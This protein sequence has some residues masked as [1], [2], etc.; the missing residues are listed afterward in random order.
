MELAVDPAPRAPAPPAVDPE[1]G[2]PKPAA[3]DGAAAEAEFL[4]EQRKY[5]LLQA[6]LAATVT[7]A[8][9]LSPPGGFWP[10]NVKGLLAGDPVLRVTYPRRYQ[11]F[12]YCNATAFVASLVTVNLLLVRSLSHRRRWLRALQAAMVLDQFGLMAAYAAGS[13]RDTA[14]SAYVFVLVALVAAYVTAHVLFFRLRPPPL[15]AAGH[16]DADADADADAAAGAAAGVDNA[17]AATPG[18]GRKDSVDRA[19]KHLLIFATLAATVTYSAGLST[20]GGFWPGSSED[21]EH[22]AGDPLLRLHHPDRFMVFFY[23]NTTAFVSSLVVIMLL[24]SSTLSRHGLRSSALWV[25]AGAAMAGL[26]GAFA[27]GS[28]RSV[29]TSIFVVSL[30]AAVLFYIGIQILVFL[31]EPV[32]ILI[33]DFQEALESYLQFRRLGEQIHQHQQ[34]Q[35]RV[36]FEHGGDGDTAAYQ[37]LRKS[38]MYL[39]LLGIL[40]ASVTYQAGLNPP[41]GFWQGDAA[42]GIHHYLAGDPILHITY[43]RRYLVFFYCNATAFV[44]SLVILI[45]LLSNI[46]STHGIK[47]CALQVAMILDLFGLVGAYAAGSCRQASK[48]VYVAVIVVPV[49]LYVGIH[50][51]VF[52]VKSFPACAAWREDTRAAMERRAPEWLKEVFERHPEGDEAM[53]RKLEKR[54]KLLLLLAILAAS[55]TYQAGM[56]PPGGFWQENESGHVV[57]N[58]TLSDNYRRRYLAFFYCNATA[59]VASLAI[60]ML[61]VNRNLSARGIRCY[62]LRVCVILDLFGLMGA[63]A[64]G[65]C[66]KVSTSVYVIALILA[67]LLCVALQVAF[68]LSETARGLVKKL[69]SMIGELELE[70]DANAGYVLPST[71]GEKAPR[72]LWDD[73]LPKYLLLLA[74]L[75]AAVTYQAAMSPPGGLWGDGGHGGGHVA[76]D[77]V[78]ASVHPHRY[79]AF[80]YCNATSFMASLVVTVLLL[81]RKVSDTPPAL[82]ALHA[83]M[84]LDLLGLMGAYAAGSCRRQKTSAYILALVVGVSAYITV[85]VFLSVGVARW[86]RSVM[87]KLVERLT[88]CFFPHD[89]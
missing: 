70:D 69:M 28:C 22:L 35:S 56:S 59:F 86:L 10:D 66:R 77:P 16:A 12:F 75:A 47:Y 25:C 58:P 88:W 21:G 37:I 51:V 74:A 4:W 20:P 11:A 13:C 33:H 46:F 42:D 87:D 9:G 73:K 5:V 80:F 79:K 60:I 34:Q 49:F 54:R 65:S 14:M 50:V 29:K 78:L 15:A 81:I 18:T 8:A 32:K 48:S 39:L 72:G 83:A 2:A 36:A 23:S 64:A 63:F 84:I 61:L 44:A 45:L 43:P 3:V 31:C 52:M 41:G 62:A 67:V 85:L 68:A 57:G 26:M 30:V 40:A 82:L 17:A 6:T 38:R 71:A 1:Q 27:S 24:M 53:E 7:Y 89:L 76:G 19:R 55:L